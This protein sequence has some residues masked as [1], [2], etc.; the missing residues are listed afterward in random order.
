MVGSFD[1]AADPALAARAFD[2]I[3]AAPGGADRLADPS[4]RRL[5]VLLLGFST[6]AADL[7]A[8]SPEELDALTDVGPRGVDALRAELDA[9]AERLGTVAGLRRFRRRAMLRIAARDLDGGDVDTIVREISDVADVCL[10]LA[11]AEAAPPSLAVVALGKLGGRELN[12]G[13]DVDVVFVHPE[14]GPDAQDRGRRAAASLIRLLSEPTDEGIALRV[15]ATLR[16]GGRSGE[17]SRSLEAMLAYYERGS[18]VWERQAL[19]K[20]RPCAG[21]LELGAAFVERVAP[22]VYPAHLEPAAID[23]VRRTKVRL[24]E[25]IRQ[26]GK[27]LVE[28]KR[29]RGGI[30]DVEFAVQLLQ[31]VHGRRDPALRSPSTLEALAALGNE[32]YVSE[33]DAAALADAYRFLRRLEHRLQIVRDLQTH[34]LPPDRHARTTIARSLGLHDADAL[35]AEYDRTT[36]L[37]RGIHERLFYRPLLEAFAG[38]AAPRPGVDRVATEELLEGLGFTAP[39]RS[40]EVLRRLVAPGSRL[41]RVLSHLFPV[42]APPLALAADPDVALVRLERIAETA[43][44][45]PAHADLLAG[46][47]AAARRLAHVAAA[48]SFATDLLV[49]RPER[50]EA[51]AGRPSDEAGE[52]VGVVARIA[53]REFSPRE[54]GEALADVADRVV[55]AAVDEADPPLPFA[56]IGMGKLGAR[57]LN[58]ASDLDV[59]FVYDGEGPED[60][61]AATATAERVLRGVRERGWEP[62]ADLRPEGRSGPLARSVAGFLE[63]WQRYAETWEFQALLRARAVAGDDALGRRFE[64]WSEEFAYPPDGL[65]LDRV[66]EI[67]KM[68][69]RIERERVKPPEATTF[70]LKLGRGSLADVQFAV[71]LSLM[72]YGGAIPEVRT[73]RTL[74]AIERLASRHLLPSSAAHDLGEAFVFLSDVKNALEI[75]RRLHAEALPPSPDEQTTLARRLGYEA[76][77]RQAFLDDYLRIARRARRAMERIFVD[78]G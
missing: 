50:L 21:D 33:G 14:T 43:V 1:A 49:A 41:G 64:G 35:Q 12:Y 11:A 59:V 22:V 76:H 15:D 75:D 32:G 53:S 55:R 30:R 71:E 26:R 38:T 17:L 74:D 10:A 3:A 9:D 73:R 13:S 25:Y 68:R 69:E 7:F 31:I 23:E 36:G 16:P 8:R 42:I 20:A 56:V 70:H 45:D 40:Y 60:L 6:A 29:G 66:A 44:A 77:A 19:L 28:V 78:P 34:D 24:E 18:A 4:V 37:V 52:L 54:T 61:A 65:T 39:A 2:R 5:A 58:V 27:D 51:L 67:R 62:D 47:P 57:E 46:D 48:S 72:R 63:Y